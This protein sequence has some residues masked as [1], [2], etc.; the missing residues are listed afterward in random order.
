MRFAF[1]RRWL[2]GGFCL[3]LALGGLAGAAAQTPAEAP[4]ATLAELRRQLEEAMRDYD[5][6]GA[7]IVLVSRDEVLWAAGMGVADRASAAPVTPDTRFRIGS[8][9]KILIALSALQQQEAG[10]LSLD[11]PL[12]ELAPE[13]AAENRWEAESPVLLSQL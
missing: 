13:I 7:G 5:V 1:W 9:S 8:I 2:V 10:R 4:A 3:W 11:D 6:P 12:S